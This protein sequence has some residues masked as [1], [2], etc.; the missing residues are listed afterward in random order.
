MILRN[1]SCFNKNPFGVHDKPVSVKFP[2][3][4]Y[5]I[6]YGAEIFKAPGLLI[7]FK[8]KATTF[9]FLK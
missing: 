2:C 6:A 5:Y 4:F 7:S 8:N 3:L 9:V 1:V